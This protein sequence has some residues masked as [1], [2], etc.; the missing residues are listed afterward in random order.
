MLPNPVPSERRQFGRRDSSIA[1]SIAI[2]GCSAQPCVMRNYSDTGALLEFREPA[3]QTHMFRLVIAD[4]NIDVLCQVRHRAPRTLGISFVGGNI[5]RFIEV[6]SPQPLI[7]PEQ[8]VKSIAAEAAKTPSIS[9]RSLR[10]EIFDRGPNSLDKPALD[11]IATAASSSDAC[12]EVAIAP[13][14][15]APTLL[16]A[17]ALQLDAI[18]EFAT[19][20]FRIEMA[21]DGSELVVCQRMLRRGI[22]RQRSSQ[23]EFTPGG[24]GLEPC[25]AASV[26]AA[27][28]QT[29]RMVLLLLERRRRV[30]QPDRIDTEASTP[31]DPAA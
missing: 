17:L 27:R 11:A 2:R 18:P 30:S 28:L 13:I 25:D 16:A 15:A 9:N 21:E 14:E 22:W 20:G 3:P 6:F 26:D 24:L 12:P 10:R 31:A 4:K 19:T 8:F 1:A 5:D 23:L 29:M 7:Q